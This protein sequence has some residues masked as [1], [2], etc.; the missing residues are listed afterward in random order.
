MGKH[1]IPYILLPDPPSRNR[2]SLA[3]ASVADDHEEE[4]DVEINAPKK[5]DDHDH[6]QGKPVSKLDYHPLH[7][8]FKPKHRPQGIRK[9]IAFWVIWVLFARRDRLEYF[10]EMQ[11]LDKAGQ[12]TTRI[13]AQKPPTR[14]GAF[15]MA[16]L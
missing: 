14:R 10:A 15:V 11:G 4:D 2:Y 8:P 1:C 5:A 12:D 9:R 16:L 6:E 13:S 7:P 3:K